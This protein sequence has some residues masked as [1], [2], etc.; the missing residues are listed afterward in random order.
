MDNLSWGTYL[1]GNQIYNLNTSENL[2]VN[3]DAYQSD[4][5]YIQRVA[6]MRTGPIQDSDLVLSALFVGQED[7]EGVP[8]NHFTLDKTN[9]RDASDPT[10]S[11]KVEEAQGDVYLA[12]DGN[13]LLYFHLKLIGHA[14]LI[15]GSTGYTQGVHEMT[16]GLSSINQ[17]NEIILPAEY[18]DQEHDRHG[19]IGQ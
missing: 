3:L 6:D 8:A 5:D 11:Y 7:F 15:P 10:A 1:M 2:A 16:E 13:Y 14:Y 18:Q 12:Q 19:V 17:L 4:L 9:L